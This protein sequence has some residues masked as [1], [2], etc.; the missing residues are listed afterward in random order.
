MKFKYRLSPDLKIAEAIYCFNTIEGFEPDANF[1]YINDFVKFK[2]FHA[3]GFGLIYK[4]DK[5]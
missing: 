2:S 1:G 5:D 3:I 4:Q